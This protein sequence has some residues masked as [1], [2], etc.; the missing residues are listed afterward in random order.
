[1]AHQTH[2]VA[3]PQLWE[4]TEQW[5]GAREWWVGGSRLRAAGSGIAIPNGGI[6]LREI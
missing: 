1:M 4:A 5:R 6:G 3:P 2:V